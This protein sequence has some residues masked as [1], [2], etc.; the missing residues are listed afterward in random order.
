MRDKIKKEE[1]FKR[2]L[3]STDESIQDIY[4]ANQLSGKI[5]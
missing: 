3:L 4:D 2:S 1:Y 5:A